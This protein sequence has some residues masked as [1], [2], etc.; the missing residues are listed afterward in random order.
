LAETARARSR[1]AA[2][3]R[4]DEIMAATRRGGRARRGQGLVTPRGDQ[5]EKRE[6]D[7]EDI[8]TVVGGYIISWRQTWTARVWWC[9]CWWATSGNAGGRRGPTFSAGQ[10]PG[11]RPVPPLPRVGRRAL[12]FRLPGMRRDELVTSHPSIQ[13]LPNPCNSCSNIS[14]H[15][16]ALGFV[17]AVSETRLS[18]SWNCSRFVRKHH[19]VAHHQ[20][21]D[22]WH[23]Q[24]QRS[25]PAYTNQVG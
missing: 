4:D 1:G 22:L 19:V 13:L 24:R 7:G 11:P 20:M 21:L 5:E 8:G 10:L 16:F 12:R 17:R 18:A 14:R 25:Y 23:R 6:R 3:I 9:W 15:T 2:A